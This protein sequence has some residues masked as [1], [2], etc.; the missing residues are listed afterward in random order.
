MEDRVKAIDVGHHDTNHDRAWVFKI[1][2]M[3][4]DSLG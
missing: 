1:I 2:M 4:V 3:L